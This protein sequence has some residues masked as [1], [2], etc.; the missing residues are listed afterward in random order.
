LL[1]IFCKSSELL[2]DRS[3]GLVYFKGVLSQLPG[4][5]GH[6]GRTPCK[7]VSV[8]LEETSEREFLFGV[9]VSPDGDFLGCFRQVEANF[10]HSRVWVQGYVCALLLW[11]LQ[12]GLVDLG[13][14]ATMTVV[15][16]L[17]AES[18][19]SSTVELSQL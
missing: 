10:L 7:D 6:V 5:T 9:E 17:Q 1:S 19:A 16:A 3:C 11:H 12:S 13:S 18:L 4:D 2:L 15:A 14:L 8:V